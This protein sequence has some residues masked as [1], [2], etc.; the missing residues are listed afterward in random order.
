MH[1]YT[2]SRRERL[3]LER[4]AVRAGFR[5]VADVDDDV[6]DPH[7]EFECLRDEYDQLLVQHRS[8]RSNAEC[9]RLAA[10]LTAVSARM[11]WLVDNEF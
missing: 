4:V 1:E 2:L 7:A 3:L 6:L 9:E 5:P 8:A 10:S 11:G